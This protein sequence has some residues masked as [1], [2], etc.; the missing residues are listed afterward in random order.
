MKVVEKL[1]K[2]SEKNKYLVIKN[3]R[4]RNNLIYIPWSVILI[5]MKKKAISVIMQIMSGKTTETSSTFFYP[6]VL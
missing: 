6:S 2:I 5:I 3:A 1:Y 4:Q